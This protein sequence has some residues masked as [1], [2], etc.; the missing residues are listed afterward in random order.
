MNCLK[1][2][3]YYSLWFEYGS[4]WFWAQAQCGTENETFPMLSLFSSTLWAGP[5]SVVREL[6]SPLVMEPM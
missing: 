3:A 6:W 2:H 1:Y 4:I 5:G